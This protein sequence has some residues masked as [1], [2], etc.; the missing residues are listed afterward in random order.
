MSRTTKKYLGVI[1]YTAKRPLKTT[2]AKVKKALTP[3]QR[4]HRLRFALA[5]IFLSPAKELLKIGLRPPK[6][7]LTALN[8]AVKILFKQNLIGP[9]PAYSIDYSHA[10]FSRWNG[11]LND[12]NTITIK[13]MKEG[14][15]QVSW[16]DATHPYTQ[17]RSSDRI[18][19]YFYNETKKEGIA[20]KDAAQRSDF[21][22]IAQLNPIH[23]GDVIHCWIFSRS[24]IGKFVSDTSYVGEIVL[25]V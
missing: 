10:V 24:L 5:N 7:T 17:N 4:E 1:S 11:D 8:Y 2:Q 9:A 25:T 23:A 22:F 21:S 19:I 6:K 20:F 15:V 13:T 14:R 12:G 16:S 18:Q 3:A